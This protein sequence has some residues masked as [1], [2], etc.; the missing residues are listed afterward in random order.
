MTVFKVISKSVD[1]VLQRLNFISKFNIVLWKCTDCKVDNFTDGINHYSDFLSCLVGEMNVFI[2]FFSRCKY[3][4]GGIVRHFLKIWYCVKKYWN[5]L[6]IRLI[7]ALCRKLYKICTECVLIFIGKI[8]CF[9]NFPIYRL[10]I[11]CNTFLCHGKALFY[12][13]CHI[14][15]K[16]HT[17]FNSEWRSLQKSFVKQTECAFFRTLFNCHSCQFF[18]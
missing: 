17:L 10:W 6:R 1:N 3:Q 13:I 15:S 2:T 5:F 12:H 14:C 18:K 4:I 11:L 16:R 9:Y 7:Q 8:F